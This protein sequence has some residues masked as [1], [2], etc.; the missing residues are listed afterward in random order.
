PRIIERDRA[1]AHQHMAFV[2]HVR[3]VDH[4]T[5]R[6]AAR[7]QP[8]I[9]ADKH[10]YASGAGLLAMNT[11]DVGR[12][13]ALTNPDRQRLVNRTAVAD[14]DIGAPRYQGRP[15]RATPRKVAAAG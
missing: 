7:P 15:R 1:Q 9:G 4:R 11:C 12:A 6:Q 2:S 8:A 5:T 14:V 13:L 3:D 10:G